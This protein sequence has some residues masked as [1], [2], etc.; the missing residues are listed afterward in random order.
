MVKSGDIMDQKLPKYV[1]GMSFKDFQIKYLTAAGT[2]GR[3]RQALEGKFIGLMNPSV[4]EHG[5][6]VK[7]LL[8]LQGKIKSEND[9]AYAELVN[10]M[11]NGKLTSL[12][13]DSTTAEYP[14][15]CAGTAW[16]KIM[17]EIGKKSAD[18]K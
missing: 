8:K 3:P 7:K 11:P 15:G 2:R 13:A 1:P 10:S 6:N 4:E 14:N 12:V 18:D 9:R 5:E 16:K 17:N